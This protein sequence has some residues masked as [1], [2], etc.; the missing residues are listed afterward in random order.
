MHNGPKS[1]TST[2]CDLHFCYVI[3][4]WPHLGIRVDRKI[5]A[6]ERTSTDEA[7]ARTATLNEVGSGSFGAAILVRDGT[8]K[9]YVLKVR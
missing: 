7:V 2:F 9:N 3:L 8:G 1:E 6:P 4:A 5:M